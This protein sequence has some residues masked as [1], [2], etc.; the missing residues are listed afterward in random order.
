MVPLARVA[1][2]KEAVGTEVEGAAASATLIGTCLL[3]H[4]LLSDFC[5]NLVRVRVGCHLLGTLFLCISKNL[6]QTGSSWRNR[7]LH[8]WPRGE[9]GNLA[10]K[11]RSR[12][13]GRQ[14][15]RG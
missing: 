7:T 4:P 5:Y 12:K 6:Q 11:R 14:I 13:F 2:V 1:P 3:R 8:M 10:A 9:T 15:P